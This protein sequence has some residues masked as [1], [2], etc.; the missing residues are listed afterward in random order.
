MLGLKYSG[1]TVLGEANPCEVLQVWELAQNR[2]LGTTV[3]GEAS[4]CE[5]FRY[6]ST[7]RVSL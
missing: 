5:V 4:P 2:Y 3:W 1:N 7:L 6:Y